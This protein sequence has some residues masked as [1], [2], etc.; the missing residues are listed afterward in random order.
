M[1]ELENLIERLVIVSAN[2]LIDVRD[3]EQHAASLLA[4]P[5]PMVEARER[6]ISLHGFEDEYIAWVIARCG[7][8]KSRAAEILGIDASTIHRRE[9][10]ARSG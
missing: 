7:G 5:S 3:L 2:E 1:R 8:N 4:G 9:Q 6:M 10:G